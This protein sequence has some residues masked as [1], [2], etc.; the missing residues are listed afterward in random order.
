MKNKREKVLKENL[1]RR[2]IDFKEKYD[3]QKVIL[4]GSYAFGKVRNFSDLDLLVIKD[5]K[6]KFC[7][8]K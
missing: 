8:G 4:F 1:D 6:S 3:P 5:T 2:I 7:Y